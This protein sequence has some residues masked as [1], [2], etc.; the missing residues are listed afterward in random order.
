[1][2]WIVRLVKVLTANADIRYLICDVSNPESVR[3]CVSELQTIL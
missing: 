3:Q 1:M 2:I